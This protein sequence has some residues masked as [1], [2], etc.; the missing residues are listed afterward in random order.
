MEKKAKIYIAGHKG[1]VGSAIKR[2]LEREGYEN[3]VYRTSSELDLKDS[4]KTEEFFIQEKPKYVFIAAAKVG[5]IKA[6]KEK[7]AEFIY[8]NLQI[9]N[10]LIHFS[11]KYG[12]KKLLF[13]SSNCMYP[14]D[15]IQPIKEGYFLTGSL[16][17]TNDA[18][19]IAKI[20][21]V[22][23]CKAYR[24][25]HG[26][27]FISIVPASLFGPNDNFDLNDSH[28]IPALI[29]RFHE[30]EINGSKEIVLWGSGKPRREIMYVDDLAEACIFLM[31]NY[32]SSEIINV[33]VGKDF[34]IK[35]IAE[36]IKEIVGFEGEIKLDA[37]KPDGMM[38]KLL[39]SSKMNNLGWN[40]R[41]EIKEG[42]KK[43]YE[44]YVGNLD[45][46]C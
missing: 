7:K 36:M 41:T 39:D 12:V 20:A 15:C 46:K 24:E 6:N 9:Q 22:M 4:K 40:P 1:L 30:A 13:L 38:R 34:E 28:F 18:Y 32:D 5:G 42:L 2:A 37:A 25:Q 33:G 17:P 35:E 19:A 11:W 45:N 43:T 8:D 31:E 29:R 23:M 3:L 27:N 44:W 14:K 21:G 16:E 10:N 26:S